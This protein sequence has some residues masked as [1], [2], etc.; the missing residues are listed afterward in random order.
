MDSNDG[1][2][3][4]EDISFETQ[5]KLH[6]LVQYL[7]EPFLLFQDF[8][9]SKQPRDLNQLVKFSNFDNS[10]QAIQMKFRKYDIKWNN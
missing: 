2:H 1:K 5:S 7:E 3:R 9:K 6:V 8:E 4:E 10:N